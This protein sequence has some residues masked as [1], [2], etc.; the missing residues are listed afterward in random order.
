MG[1]LRFCRVPCRNACRRAGI[2]P[3]DLAAPHPQLRSM[4]SAPSAPPGRGQEPCGSPRQPPEERLSKGCKQDTRGRREQSGELLLVEAPASTSPRQ[5]FPSTRGSG[6][7]SNP[8][9]VCQPALNHPA[10]PA[11]APSSALPPGHCQEGPAE[12]PGAPSTPNPTQPGS[13][14]REFMP[15]VCA[16]VSCPALQEPPREGDRG[17]LTCVTASGP[18]G[19]W[20]EAAR[21]HVHQQT[22]PAFQELLESS[23]FT[24]S[25]ESSGKWD[26]SPGT[27]GNPSALQ[28][29]FH[30]PAGKC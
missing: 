7:R 13:R 3:S 1:K 25:N 30:I 21:T 5:P 11:S 9:C 15:Q 26:L 22:P 29:H 19:P 14:P 16:G 18:V 8:T 6:S 23:H 17:Q 28:P 12:G 10:R 4:H 27:G 2:R 20:G 24:F